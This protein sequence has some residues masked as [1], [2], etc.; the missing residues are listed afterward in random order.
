MSAGLRAIEEWEAHT[1][2]AIVLYTVSIL[3]TKIEFIAGMLLVFHF[4]KYRCLKRR[5]RRFRVSMSIFRLI[6]ISILHNIVKHVRIELRDS[7]VLSVV[8][9]FME[10]M[11]G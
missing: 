5:R 10:F 8:Q 6:W 1:N 7:V 11:L 2:V 3:T 4:K 9:P